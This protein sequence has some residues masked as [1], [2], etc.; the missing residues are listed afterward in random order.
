MHSEWVKCGPCQWRGLAAAAAGKVPVFLPHPWTLHW[1]QNSSFL[2]KV[3]R[4]GRQLH[5]V[6][7]YCRE[8]RTFKFPET[9]EN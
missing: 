5:I 1:Q 7:A 2:D 9:E 6:S 8:R 4:P 3:R